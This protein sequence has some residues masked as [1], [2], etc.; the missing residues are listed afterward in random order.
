MR[1]QNPEE[2]KEQFFRQQQAIN[3]DPKKIVF[4][5]IN[6]LF[7]LK[8]MQ[9]TLSTCAKTHLSTLTPQ[10]LLGYHIGL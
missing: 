1:L 3:R 7:K 8:A 4:S 10:R 9:V 2:D 6:Y 5:Q